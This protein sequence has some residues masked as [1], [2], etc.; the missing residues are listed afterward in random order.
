MPTATQTSNKSAKHLH[1]HCLRSTQF[2]ALETGSYVVGT[3]YNVR[4]PQLFSKRLF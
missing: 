3:D 4:L 2:Q 1:T